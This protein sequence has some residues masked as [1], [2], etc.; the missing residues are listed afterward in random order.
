[1]IPTNSLT[2]RITLAAAGFIVL[3]ALAIA[4][5]S[6]AHAH[7]GGLAKDGCH[8][9]NAAGERHWHIDGTADRGGECVKRDGHT[10]KMPDDPASPSDSHELENLRLLVEAQKAQLADAIGQQANLETTIRNLRAELDSERGKS[11]AWWQRATRAEETVEIAQL[12]RNRA[13]AA[14]RGANADAAA[15]LAEAQE[16]KKIAE[17]AELRARGIGPRVDRRC[18]AAVEEI[19]H[20]DTG[21][22]SD[23]VEVDS[24]GRA[25]LSRACLAQ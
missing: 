17:D 5:G 23:D 2:R 10:F 4:I 14:A 16:S 12:E 15:A 13:L 19:V 7:P 11:H 3:G 20:G 21:W 25:E 24:E 18:R 22:L 1:M 6:A 8:K 9:D